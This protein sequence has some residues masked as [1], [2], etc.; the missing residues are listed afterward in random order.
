[1]KKEV[2]SLIKR[3][4]FICVEEP[5]DIV[6][7][8]LLYLLAFQISTHKHTISGRLEAA[9]AAHE[10]LQIIIN[11][12]GNWKAGDIIKATTIN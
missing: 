5:D 9:K 2:A 12:V 6:I 10:D 11:H 7:E 3:L 4:N 8:S 1:M